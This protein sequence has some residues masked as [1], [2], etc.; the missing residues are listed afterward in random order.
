MTACRSRCTISFSLTDGVLEL[1]A[2][3]AASRSGKGADSVFMDTEDVVDVRGGRA[4]RCLPE[5]LL[6]NVKKEEVVH[7]VIGMWRYALRAAG[8]V[9]ARNRLGYCV[10]IRGWRMLSMFSRVVNLSEAESS[11]AGECCSPKL[12]PVSCIGTKGIPSS[13]ILP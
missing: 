4:G 1:M 8:R 9:V 12:V 5:S 3:P 6:R 11:C 10:L 7:I 2:S 13:V